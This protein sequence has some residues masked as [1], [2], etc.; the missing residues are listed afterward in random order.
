MSNNK[1]T[2]LQSA[3]KELQRLTGLSI[4]IN[5]P[6]SKGNLGDQTSGDPE[7]GGITDQ[8]FK[9]QEELDR[10]I[11]QIK[12]LS[13]A[14]RMANDKEYVVKRWL[15]GAMGKD[16]FTKAAS[17]LRLRKDGRRVVYLIRL[18]KEVTSEISLL[19]KSLF[20]DSSSWL[21][22]M[23]NKQLVII[24]HFP[25]KGMPDAGE[26]ASIL[27]SA[28]N[29]ELMEQALISYSDMLYDLFE[30]PE[31]YRQAVLAMEAGNTFTPDKLIFGYADIG[32]GR[33][34]LDLSPE[35]CR[36]Y[37]KEELGGEFLFGEL[38]AFSADLQ[39][40]ADCFIDN[41]FNIAET[42]RKLHIH[43]N[44]L[45]YRL[46][47]ILHETGLDIRQFKDAMT[48]RM[49]SMILLLLKR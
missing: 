33:L 2:A 12:A 9:D 1:D 35:V 38:A 27:L 49:C 36:S 15:T 39:K 23:D 34:V 41:N 3:I 26:T 8:T 24:Y 46:E 44:T 43:R 30:L 28:L 19:L 17:R 47:Q 4:S 10:T 29:T 6:P 5:P 45:L 13:S 11:Q 16:E 31:A 40:T 42:S 21:I 7:E 48:Y 14:Y 18:N 22:P 32:I 20:P 37:I 25:K